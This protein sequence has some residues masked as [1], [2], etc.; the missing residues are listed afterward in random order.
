MMAIH[1]ITN[2]F[3]ED[4]YTL[5]ALRSSM[6]GYAMAYE[7]NRCLKSKFKRCSKDLKLSQDL[8]FAAFEWK[9]N[10]NYVYWTLIVNNTFKQEESRSL[11]LFENEPSF[12]KIQVIPEHKDADYLLKIEHDGELEIDVVKSLQKIPKVITAYPIETE[13]L[14]SKTNLIIY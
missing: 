3:S 11:D 12:K 6:E 8:S 2:D 10:D 13:N 4:S 5:I 1:K 14:K 7:L 9:D